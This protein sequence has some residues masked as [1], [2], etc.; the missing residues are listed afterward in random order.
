MII[1]SQL[2]V[3]ILISINNSTM[4]K[5]ESK[6]KNQDTLSRAL[7][8]FKNS[9]D[10]PLTAKILASPI[11]TEQIQMPLTI[12]KIFPSHQYINKTCTMTLSN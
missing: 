6:K 8:L 11:D 9:I 4:K 10:R 5:M 3:N 2:K 12:L 7:Y 1:S